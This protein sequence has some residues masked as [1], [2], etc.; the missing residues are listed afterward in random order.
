MIRR[1][2]QSACFSSRL[3]GSY[4]LS[5]SAVCVSDMHEELFKYQLPEP[6][7]QEIDLPSTFKWIFIFV[8]LASLITCPPVKCVERR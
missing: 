6:A 1:V 7:K 2:M 5:W 4:F 3:E 8:N